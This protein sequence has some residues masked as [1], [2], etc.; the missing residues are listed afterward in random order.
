MANRSGHISPVGLG[1][2]LYQGPFGLE[3][4]LCA[5]A[6]ECLYVKDAPCEDQSEPVPFPGKE[7]GVFSL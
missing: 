2:C 5:R 7:Q 4:G 3:D 1:K 6:L